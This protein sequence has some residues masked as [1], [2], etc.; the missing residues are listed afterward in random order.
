MGVGGVGCSGDGGKDNVGRFRGLWR[1]K[2]LWKS[3]CKGSGVVDR[4]GRVGK[5]EV[6]RC[7]SN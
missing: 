1:K 4:I 2:E 6:I 3:K 7:G 5:E